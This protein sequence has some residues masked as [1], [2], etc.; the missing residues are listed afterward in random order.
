MNIWWEDAFNYEPECCD[1]YVQHC[2]WP[3]PPLGPTPS[4]FYHLSPVS[5][6]GRT[7][8]LS[9][10]KFLIFRKIFML[11]KNNFTWSICSLTGS[12]TVSP[13][14]VIASLWTG[15]TLGAHWGVGNTSYNAQWAIRA[16]MSCLSCY[17][18]GVD[19]SYVKNWMTY[20]WIKTVIKYQE[21]PTPMYYPLCYKRVVKVTT[22]DQT[23]ASKYIQISENIDLIKFTNL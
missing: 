3:S 19:S 9:P 6:Y 7:Y 8:F 2:S 21:L 14:I 22:G 20:F 16:H 23:P 10:E 5:C 18:W 13:D 4:C 12:M 15:G 1:K 17:W 11:L